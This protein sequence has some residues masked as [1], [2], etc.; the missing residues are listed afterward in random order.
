MKLC[1]EREIGNVVALD[2]VQQTG[3]EF[4]ATPCWAGEVLEEKRTRVGGVRAPEL[5]EEN[6]ENQLNL[7]IAEFGDG[8]FLIA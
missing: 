5:L 7:G 6:G 4:H 3:E 2:G 8:A 1:R